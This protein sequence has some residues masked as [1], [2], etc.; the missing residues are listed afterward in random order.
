MFTYTPLTDKQIE[1]ARQP[2]KEG[3][4]DFEVMSA[5]NKVSKSGYQMIQLK[6][7]IWTQEG[8]I[9]TFSDWL[10]ALDSMIWKVKHFWESVGK[11]ELYEQG[12]PHG[13]DYVGYAGKLVIGLRKNKEGEQALQVIDYVSKSD[14][15][16]AKLNDIPDDDIPF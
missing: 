9:V 11:P 4:Y 5:E 6:H 2:L 14:P 3:I 15:R 8:K 12:V 10:V 7:K 16:A 13:K 1:E